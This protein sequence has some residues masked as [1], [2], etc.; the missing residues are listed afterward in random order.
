VIPL[1]CDMDGVLVN[2]TG[3]ARFD[4]M[5]WMPDGRELWDFIKPHKPRILS[6]LMKDIW[7]VSRHE[8]R[9]WVERELGAGVPV[10]VVRAEE[11][12]HPYSG[13]G[14]VLIDDSI[15]HKSDWEAKG[16]IFVHHLTAE[17]SIEQLRKILQ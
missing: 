16:G 15:K 8:K 5:D 11:G 1:Y 13:P 14:A 3:R 17:R 2:Q 7:D 10:T 9:I 4:L 6:Q 12:K